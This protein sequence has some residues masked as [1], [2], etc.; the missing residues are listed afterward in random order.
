[1]R[2]ESDRILLGVFFLKLQKKLDEKN[3]FR[4]LNLG[5]IASYSK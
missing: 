1:M 4:S 2:G 3:I 5:G